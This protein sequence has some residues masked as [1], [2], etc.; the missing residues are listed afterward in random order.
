MNNESRDEFERLNND[1]SNYFFQNY[2]R[3]ADNN[4]KTSILNVVIFSPI[5]LIAYILTSIYYSFKFLKTKCHILKEGNTYLVMLNC[6]SS[7]RKINEYLKYYDISSSIFVYDDMRIDKPNTSAIGMTSLIPRRERLRVFNKVFFGSGS[8]IN[9]IKAVYSYSK[10]SGFKNRF[11]MYLGVRFYLHELYSASFEAL[12]KKFPEVEVV[13]SGSTNERYATAMDR[14]THRV[15]VESICVPH[16]ISP[17]FELPNGLFG[18]KYFCL[19]KS[20]KD[21]LTSLYE[22]REYIY[23]KNLL[24]KLLRA[25][26]EPKKEKKK[27]VVFTDSRSIERDQYLIDILSDYGSE[28]SLKLHPNDNETNYK[29]PSHCSIITSFEHAINN[30]ICITR[31]S[32]IL[33]DAKYNHS[34][35]IAYLES[36]EDKYNSQSVYLGLY[37]EEVR[38][39]F[40]KRDLHILINEIKNEK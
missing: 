3:C 40:N 36:E 4:S 37:D 27:L 5:I 23:D 24:N 29:F 12:L 30:S 7:Y 1:F 31:V 25:G 13:V 6:K 34:I 19:S 32:S 21:I 17:S 38:C 16:G 15:G 10:V 8:F 11:I 14:I 9:L 18:K 22:D 26:D 35:P 2:S 33:I 39:V 28:F 20:E